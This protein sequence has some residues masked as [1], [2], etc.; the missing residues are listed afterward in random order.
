MITRRNIVKQT[1]SARLKVTVES[2]AGLSACLTGPALGL[3]GL[4]QGAGCRL[5]LAL[6]GLWVHHCTSL[7]GALLQCDMLHILVKQSV[8]GC[9]VDAGAFSCSLTALECSCT[10]SFKHIYTCKSCTGKHCTG[11][12][13]VVATTH[14][15]PN[16]GHNSHNQRKGTCSAVTATV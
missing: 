16:Q 11:R 6:K 9:F 3:I 5:V 8:A 12:S 13:K 15:Q 1:N 14:L 2:A 4:L 7:R 10:H